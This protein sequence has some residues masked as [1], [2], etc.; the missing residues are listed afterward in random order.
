[1]GRVFIID[2]VLVEQKRPDFVMSR[3]ISH[4]IAE[5]GDSVV[6]L[7][8]KKYERE[9]FEIGS[10]ILVVPTFSVDDTATAG[11]LS[12]CPVREDINEEEALIDIDLAVDLVLAP[13]VHDKFFQRK[14]FK[15][16]NL[17]RS[18][19]KRLFKK[20]PGGLQG[21]IKQLANFVNRICNHQTKD[22]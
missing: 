10:G 9:E 1:M 21:N 15:K 5:N 14:L 12:G 8:N 19:P 2:P 13:K 20:L 22:K 6:L 7:A 16:K 18:F 3:N 4:I 17:K 11:V